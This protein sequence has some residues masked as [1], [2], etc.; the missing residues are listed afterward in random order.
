MKTTFAEMELLSR[1]ELP[2]CDAERGL[3]LLHMKLCLLNFIH[4]SRTRLPLPLQIPEDA[5]AKEFLIIVG[6]SA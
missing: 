2:V 5:I 3:A 4:Q 1:W 6:L